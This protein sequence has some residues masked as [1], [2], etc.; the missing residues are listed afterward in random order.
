MLKLIHAS[1]YNRGDTL[2]KPLMVTM[3]ANLRS[4]GIGFAEMLGMLELNFPNLTDSN[5]PLPLPQ[6]MKKLSKNS[7]ILKPIHKW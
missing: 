2:D 1:S 7:S 3:T 4:F 6:L 5:S